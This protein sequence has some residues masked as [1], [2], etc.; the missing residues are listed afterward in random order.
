MFA[1]SKLERCRMKRL[2]L[3][4]AILVICTLRCKAQSQ[5]DRIKGRGASTFEQFSNTATRTMTGTTPSVAGGNVFKTNNGGA[6]TVT[7]F[8]NGVDSQLITVICGETNTLIQ[9]NAN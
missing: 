4:C 8:L 6:T 5:H 2:V 3:F 9:N 7:N 1:A